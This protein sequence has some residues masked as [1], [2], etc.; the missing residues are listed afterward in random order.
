VKLKVPPAPARAR[1][2]ARHG[3]TKDEHARQTRAAQLATQRR[4]ELDQLG[5]TVL[6][7]VK[8]AIELRYVID[9]LLDA[10]RSSGATSVDPRRSTR[11]SQP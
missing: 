10:L 1:A 11:T 9:V 7:S 2:R 8:E 4:Q 3:L 5:A 6:A